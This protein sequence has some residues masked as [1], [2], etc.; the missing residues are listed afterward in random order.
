MFSWSLTASMNFCVSK[1][2]LW[3]CKP[4]I[5]SPV[6]HENIFQ[7]P[8]SFWIALF[9]MLH[10]EIWNFLFGAMLFVCAQKIAIYTARKNKRMPLVKNTP[11]I[12]MTQ[13]WHISR[14]LLHC[15]GFQKEQQF[16]KLFLVVKKYLRVLI[17]CIGVT[18]AWHSSGHMTSEFLRLCL[19]I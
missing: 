1:R 2:K 9:L 19:W 18:W 16:L 13:A 4:K 7:I 11:W 12:L 17:K 3:M 8:L 10:K 6:L 15:F 5:T 14:I